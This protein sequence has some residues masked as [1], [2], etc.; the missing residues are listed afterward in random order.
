MKMG[1][2]KPVPVSTLKKKERTKREPIK[3][4]R[5]PEDVTRWEGEGG[6]IVPTGTIPAVHPVRPSSEEGE[7]PTQKRG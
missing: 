4:K 6:A 3:N 1:N 2:T 5:K 7:E